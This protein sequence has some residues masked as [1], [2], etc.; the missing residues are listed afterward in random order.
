VA[1]DVKLSVVRPSEVKV[2]D[3]DSLM[4][5]AAILEPNP[6]Q[7]IFLIRR[8]K[9]S[10]QPNATQHWMQPIH[11]CTTSLASNCLFPHASAST[12]IRKS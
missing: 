5:L 8:G 11:S 9:K 1:I 2:G 12:E 10:V 7:A 4:W 6:V 3:C